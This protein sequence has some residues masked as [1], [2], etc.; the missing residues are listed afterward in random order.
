MCSV[1]CS[2]G[3]PECSPEDHLQSCRL[4]WREGR[5]FCTCPPSSLPPLRDLPSHHL[6]PNPFQSSTAQG[7]LSLVPPLL[8]GSHLSQ[9]RRM[10]LDPM[11]LIPTALSSA[12]R[13]SLP[14]LVAISA[15]IIMMV[16]ALVV[17][18]WL[19]LVPTY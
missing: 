19:R 12:L 2:G 14:A 6:L 15:A 18:S 11:R 7:N 10:E 16:L 5:R 4:R 3:C 1:N 17:L 8:P 13:D 9:A